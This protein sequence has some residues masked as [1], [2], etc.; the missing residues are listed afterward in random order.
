MTNKDV[1]TVLTQAGGKDLLLPERRQELTALLHEK[2]LYTPD[3]QGFLLCMSCIN[4]GSLL[5]RSE[6]TLTEYQNLL[7]TCIQES[8][9]NYEACAEHLATL[10][11]VL[12]VDVHGASEAAKNLLPEETEP[13]EP[14]KMYY[15]YDDVRSYLMNAQRKQDDPN[16]ASA[17]YAELMRADVTEAF[18]QYGCLNI[19][20]EDAETRKKG[21]ESLKTAASRGNIP[22]ALRLGDHYMASG[23]YAAAEKY[24]CSFGGAALSA[25]RRGNVYILELI[26]RSGLRTVIAQV[27]LA[28]LF[29]VFLGITAAA[30]LR[31]GQKP[32]ALFELLTPVFSALMLVCTGWSA[33]RFL[34]NPLRQ[35]RLLFFGEVFCFLAAVCCIFAG[36]DVTV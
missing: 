28:L 26:K 32:S 7:R 5:E 27:I 29:A 23:N 16:A 34:R 9:L 11:A 22:A 13:K 1:L 2:Q 8:H 24:Y 21:E 36:M 25:E 20:S 31:S 19:A 30:A 6:L 3:M 15:S 12:H 18:Y 33:L 17:L 10:F 35:S 14:P 4:P